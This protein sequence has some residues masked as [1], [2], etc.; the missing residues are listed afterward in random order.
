MPE[1]SPGELL[2]QAARAL[3]RRFQAASELPPHA[4]RALRVLAEHG[5]LPNNVLAQELHIAPRSATEV[6]DLLIERGLAQRTQDPSDGR[7]RLI[8]L[9]PAGHTAAATVAAVRRQESAAFLSA[10]D[11]TEQAQLTALLAKLVAIPGP[12]RA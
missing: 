4:G 1:Y 6:A 10:L 9:T 2:L 3:R 11:E 5:P 8:V 12:D 7:V